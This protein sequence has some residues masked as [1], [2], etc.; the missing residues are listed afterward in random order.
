MKTDLTIHSVVKNEPFLYYTIKAV[1]DYCDEIL[2]YDT[3]STDE[4]TLKDIKTLL[5]ED[6]ENKIRFK[7]V[8]LDFDEEKWSL[9]NL[10]TFIPEHRG[11]MSVGKCRQMQIDE[12]KTKYF[13]L[14][15]GDEVHYKKTMELIT[16]S[17][18]PNWPEGKLA[19]GLPLIW[20]FDA[21][22]TFTTGTFPVN[23]RIY[24]TDSVYMSKDSPNEQH[25]IKSGKHQGE[26]FTYEHPCYLKYMEATPYAHFESAIRAW[27]RKHL[28]PANEPKL[29]TGRFPDVM[30]DYPSFFRRFK[31][32]N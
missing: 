21:D 29:F 7:E 2:L 3:G 13:M 18:L 27:R 4:N 31:D 24:I 15:D 30:Y 8:K 26:F 5:I 14:V 11:K 32:A 19:I 1:Y 16:Q 10:E 25:L 23:G 22:H 28:V 17:L 20:F 9:A 6:T 12:T